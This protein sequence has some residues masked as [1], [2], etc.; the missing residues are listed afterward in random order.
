MKGDSKRE[1][2]GFTE[3]LEPTALVHEARLRLVA[4]PLGTHRF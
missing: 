4:N 2:A 3:A 1:M